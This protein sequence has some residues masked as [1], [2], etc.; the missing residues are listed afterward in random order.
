MK[1]LGVAQKQN[2]QV[3]M[4]DTFT[5]V[6][7][8]QTY[9]AIDVGGDILLIVPPGDRERLLR[10]ER[11]ANRSIDEHRSSLEGLAK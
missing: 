4:P 6:P 3:L 9:E 11:L 8:G 2:C 10:I 7:N 1:Y 5:S